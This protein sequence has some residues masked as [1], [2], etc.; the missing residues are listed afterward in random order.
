M[1]MNTID[2]FSRTVR[3]VG[4]LAVSLLVGLAADVGAEGSKEL[5]ANGG[6]RPWLMYRNDTS[7]GSSVTNRTV[8]NV[9]AQVNETINLGS[10]VRTANRIIWYAPNGVSGTNS[11]TGGVGIISNRTQEVAGPLPNVGG[12]NPRTITVTNGQAGVWEVHFLSPD[13]TSDDNPNS[14]LAT[15]NWTQPASGGNVAAWDVTV[16]SAGGTAIPGRV[17]AN[18]IS[19]NMG[20][21]VNGGTLRSEVYYLTA[22]GYRYRINLNSVDPYRFQFFANNRGFRDGL[23]AP[24]FK[25]VNLAGASVHNPLLPDT[26][27]DIT[28]KLFFNTPAGDLPNSAATR[29]GTTWLNS[30]PTTVIT[31]NIRFIG[32]DGTT[33]Q[34]GSALGG[35]FTF[36]ATGPGSYIINIDLNGDGAYTSAVDRVLLGTAYTGTNT[37]FWDGRDGQGNPAPGGQSIFNSKVAVANGEVHFPFADAE[38]C[39]SGIVIERLN[40]PTNDMYTIYWDDTNFG[41]GTSAL[42]PTG[43]NSVAGAHSWLPSGNSGFGNAR[44]IDTWVFVPG[45]FEQPSSPISIK[46]TDLELVSFSRTPTFVKPNTNV[47]YVAVI[48]NNGPDNTPQARFL[49]IFPPGLTNLT[50]LSANFTGS[51]AITSG[52]F[53]NGTY[54]ARIQMNVGEVGTLT[55]RGNVAA[56]LGSVLTN[57][58]QFLTYNDVGDVNDPDRVGAGNNGNTNIVAVTFTVTGTV[59]NDANVNAVLDGETGT[60][61]GSLYAKLINTNSPATAPQAALVDPVTGA[62]TLTTTATGGYTV[63]LDNNS[64]LADV[65]PALPAGWL[66]TEAVGQRRTGLTVN[67]DVSGINFGLYNGS[68]LLLSTL[69]N[70][71]VRTSAGSITMS[72]IVTNTSSISNALTS[73]INNL[74]NVPGAATY[75]NGSSAYNGN[76]I[77]NPTIVSVTNLT[78]NGTFAVPA[79]GVGTLTFAINLPANLGV[80]TNRTFA[81]VSNTQIDTTASTADNA[82]A[83]ETARR[84]AAPNNAPTVQN[85]VTSVNAGTN[86]VI[87]PSA[88]DAD[89]DPLTLFI[90]TP[91]A[92]GSV[93]IN[94][95]LTF[96]YTPLVTYFGPDSFTYRATDGTS[97]SVL[98]TASIT[99]FDVT[100][101]QI[102]Q[103]PTNQTAEAG[104]GCQAAVPNFTAGVTAT[105]NTGAAPTL[106][107]NPLAG[108]LANYGTNSILVI[109]TDG[110]ANTAT[111][112]ALFV[113]IDTTAPTISQCAAPVVVNT[114]AGT[115]IATNVNLGSAPTA[116]DFCGLGT[117]TSNAPAFFP[118]G[119]NTVTWTVSDTHGNIATCQQSVVV[120]DTELPQLACPSD[121]TTNLPAGLCSLANLALGTPVVSDNAGIASVVSNAPAVFNIGT[122]S[123]VWTVTDTSGNSAVCTQSVTVLDVTPPQIVSL[124]VDPTGAVTTNCQAVVPDLTGQVVT[125]DDCTTTNNLVIVQSP[126]AGTLADLG[127]SPITFTVTDSAGNST[128]AAVTFTVTDET[129]PTITCPATVIVIAPAGTNAVGNVSLGTPVTED[130]CGVGSVTNDAPALFLVGDTT[131][132]WTVVDDSGNTN[133]CAQTVTVLTI[134]HAPVANADVYT[135]SQNSAL[136]VS[137]PGLLANDSDPDGDPIFAVI[138]TPPTNGLVTVNADGSFAYTPNLNFVGT[139][140]FSYKASDGNLSSSNATITIVV[141]AVNQLAQA[142][143]DSF[144]TPV[145]TTLNVSAP[146]VLANDTDS[147]G[148]P[149]TAVLVNDVAHGT[150]T[151]NPDGSFE[152]I[153][154]AGYIGFDYFT[155]VANDGTADSA[156]VVVTLGVGLGAV[157]VAIPDSYT[158]DENQ[159]LIVNATSGVLSNDTSAN[160]LT[161]FLVSG[162]QH[163]TLT[164][165]PD[166]SFTYTPNPG[167]SGTDSFVYRATDGTLVSSAAI[168][169]F[170]VNSVDQPPVANPDSY[171]ATP[172]GVLTVDALTGVLANDYDPEG[173]PVTAVVVDDV[174]N[175]VLVFNPDGSFQ[176]T[177]DTGFVGTDSFTYYATDGTTNS[178]PVT[179]TLYVAANNSV[180]VA[181]N[182]SFAV[183]KNGT[184]TIAAPGVL[185]NDYDDDGNPLTAALET[186]VAHG[187]LTFNAD[188]SFEYVPNA[189]FTGADSF[190]YKLN[191][192]TADS[193]VATVFITVNNVILIPTV[194]S[195]TPTA[196]SGSTLNV[197]APGAL[198]GSTAPNGLPLTTLLVTNVA[199][200][201]LVLNGDGSYSYTPNP[202]FLGV[203]CFVFA[204]TDGL[205]T[206]ALASVCITVE[207]ATAPVITACASNQTLSAGAN[208]QVALPDLTGNVTVTDNSGT[209]TVTQS[210]VAGT[211]LNLGTNT[212]TLIAADNAG[213]ASTCTASVVVLDTTAPVI[214]LT[215]DTVI[216]VAC[217]GSFSDPG[218]TASD[219]C[220]G[221]LTGSIVVTGTVNTSAVG[222]YT[223]YYNVADP[224][225]NAA[226]QVTRTVSVVDT[227][228]PSITCPGNVVVTAPA[229][230]NS[231]TGVSLGSPSASDGCG[232]VSVSNDAPGSFPL[233]DTIVTWTADDGNG[234]TATCE[235]TVTVLEGNTPP[236]ATDGSFDAIQDGQLEV[237]APGVLTFAS[238]ADNDS[239]T[240]I[241]ITDPSN[242][243][244]TLNPDG[245]FTYVPDAGFTGVDSF[246]YAVSDG[247]AQ[248]GTATITITVG[249]S[250]LVSDL[251]LLAGSASFK[252]SWVKP[253]RDR[254]RLIGRVNPRGARIDLTGATMLVT[255]NGLDLSAPLVL[256]AKGRGTIKIGKTKIKAFLSSKTG[257]FKF[258]ISNVDLTDVLDL[259]SGSGSSLM[260]LDIVLTMLGGDFDIPVVGGIFETPYKT[261]A[262]KMSKARF[263][264]KSHR[265]LTGVFNSNKTTA[266]LGKANG[267]SVAFK[268][269]IENILDVPIVPTGPV[270]IQIGNNVLFVPANAVNGK[271]KLPGLKTFRLDTVKHTFRLKTTE[272][273]STGIP[274]PGPGADLSYRLPMT[275]QVPNGATTNLFETIIELKRKTETKKAWKR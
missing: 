113:V 49:Q 192:G 13:P 225:G 180:P 3:R 265:T 216:N 260:N 233:G 76:A 7:D 14:I 10:S 55:F 92:N 95:N 67:N 164:L 74:P 45:D 90:V 148:D 106:T 22:D 218:A 219:I 244:L 85:V 86:V 98:G 253:N 63:I 60:S 17:Y 204:G 182:D 183:N 107:Q 91:P 46:Q 275:I 42:P 176:Y 257:K 205:A 118:L 29:S 255:V 72:V 166:G 154:A 227:T 242:G 78:W 193:S 189:G 24:L 173:L 65:T 222:T 80:Y 9:Y 200:G 115:N 254:L 43:S 238:D 18:L 250:G 186:D 79:T 93:I 158:L 231:V 119:S 68:Y 271:V 71:T 96:T 249:A 1:T 161:A 211:L 134:N 178:G 195:S 145:D 268:G 160:P 114:G 230:S 139:D 30:T 5:C 212:I 228:A 191:D 188:G 240:A 58:T 131:V 54:D 199:N 261:K 175:G 202:N 103:G 61:L 126:V 157:P 19:M 252:K 28:H 52:G 235:Q 270:R 159:S 213:N 127:G 62:Y 75:V 129:L 140:S 239:L 6:Y 56:G 2:I 21:W 48:R 246:T 105:D 27:T 165:N 66:G 245:S 97:N 179:V 163:G 57:I 100:P 181:N 196:S 111:S 171:S 208:C 39:Y 214:T 197:P 259:P 109:A 201:T 133:T 136:L 94:P 203:D 88:A 152:Y 142:N 198:T 130:N 174:A 169:T 116:S 31:S 108:A 33:N 50:L 40:G 266:K 110:S 112:T 224:A 81:L 147:D 258:G 53:T 247:T 32:L 122:T 69:A 121:I 34:V 83:I 153:P 269:A 226:T 135:N 223:L 184:L 274:L 237:S 215:G 217:Q 262:G 44:G 236:V 37:V 36:D 51:A 267:Y 77:G 120:L 125:T 243:T 99:V 12:Y 102:T 124:P 273:D 137:A 38:G 128:N 264:F 194:Q 35:N 234:N 20:D 210:P 256:D 207:D 221:T 170:T 143:P 144:S 151:L 141:E 70:P 232:T 84:S 64:T 104:T 146:G 185:A 117:I 251:E 155:Y 272:L 187:V 156:P 59:Y 41:G 26:A 150:L 172:D 15:S 73:I 123:V 25:S 8:I 167:F 82:P 229:G 190:S 101:P 149:L 47:T 23:G 11:V 87:N 16:R 4:I 132:T 209:F 177:P 241:K 263:K 168:V 206:S 162:P 248:S 220:A 138:V 89:N